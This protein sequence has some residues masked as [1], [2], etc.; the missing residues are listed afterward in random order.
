M[1][2][3]AEPF[4]LGTSR[5]LQPT[6]VDCYDLEPL[7]ALATAARQNGTDL[8]RYQA[9]SGA[10]LAKSLAFLA[11]FC[12]GTQTHPEFVNSRVA[13]DRRRAESGDRTYQSGRTSPGGHSTRARR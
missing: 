5:R 13:F 10:S 8:Y 12:D 1:R 3:S 9:P 2:E 6:V 4:G 11:P 7:L